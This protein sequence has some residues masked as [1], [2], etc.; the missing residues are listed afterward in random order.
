MRHPPASAPSEKPS[1]WYPEISQPKTVSVVR[2]HY[3]PTDPAAATQVLEVAAK[4]EVSLPFRPARSPAIGTCDIEL[5][6]APM[7]VDGLNWIR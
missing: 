3:R 6:H 1:L 7:A 4:P 5:L 2:L